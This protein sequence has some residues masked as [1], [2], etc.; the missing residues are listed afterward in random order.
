MV[1]STDKQ[2]LRQ[3]RKHR[4]DGLPFNS[5]NT[6]LRIRET[7]QTTGSEHQ[8]QNPVAGG[9]PHSSAQLSEILTTN[10]HI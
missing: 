4:R 5:S 9:D 10:F 2:L 8:L 3:E 7:T 6:K 1:L